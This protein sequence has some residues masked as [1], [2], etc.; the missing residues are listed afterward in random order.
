MGSG[1]QT[2]QSLEAMMKSLFY[3]K[4]DGKILMHFEQE[5]QMF[6]VDTGEKSGF[7]WCGSGEKSEHRKCTGTTGKEQV[8]DDDGCHAGDRHRGDETQMMIRMHLEERDV[9]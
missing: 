4:Y 6:I 1:A 2:S 5:M 7:C 8:R 3:L 9:G